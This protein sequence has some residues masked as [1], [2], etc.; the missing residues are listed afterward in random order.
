M[1][2]PR[3]QYNYALQALGGPALSGLSRSDLQNPPARA[4]K[5][6]AGLPVTSARWLRDTGGVQRD[7]FYRLISRDEMARAGKR[8][9]RRLSPN[10]SERVI[11]IA[12]VFGLATEAL[13]AQD[14]GAMFMRRPHMLLHDRRPVDQLDT[15]TGAR[16][17]ATILMR[18]MHGI[19]P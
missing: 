14:R 9:E 18:L 4:A 19:P 3:D 13:G 16:A 17:V 6:R 7:D 2:R 12:L 1:S 8:V 15:E 11:R 5:A 10:A